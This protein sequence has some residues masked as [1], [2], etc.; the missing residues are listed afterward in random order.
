MM[1][2]SRLPVGEETRRRL[3]RSLGRLSHAY[4]ISG[5]P[6]SGADALADLLAAAYVCSGEGDKP[7]GSCPGCRKANER[8]HP[9]IIRLTVPEGKRII[10]VEQVR[11]LRADAYIRPNEAPRKVYIIEDAQAMNDSA[12]NALLKVL[13]D[14]PRYLS[15]LLLTQNSQQLL[16]TIRSR[17]E[18]LSLAAQPGED[19]PEPDAQLLRWADELAGLLAG[20]EERALVEYTVMLESK[21]WEAD[22]LS[23]FLDAVEDA[24]RARL[25]ARPARMLP[26]MEHL[27][28]IRQAIPFHVGTGHLFG[29]LASGVVRPSEEKL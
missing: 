5:P 10:T 16:P 6:G 28:Q 23:A 21:K 26:L 17:C 7:C 29:W 15:F 20:G 2:L 1:N 3:E 11:Q 12:Q 22:D 9:D 14:G 4:I 24:L 27:K 8:I 19:A 25:P 18:T 13:E